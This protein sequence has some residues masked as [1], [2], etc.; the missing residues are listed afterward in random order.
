MDKHITIIYDG[1]CQFCIRALRLLKRFD[2]KQT[3]EMLD[4]H[5]PETLA[6]FPQVSYEQANEAM[7]VISPKGKVY[8]GFFAFRRLILDLPRLWPLL[9][10]FYFPG[11]F[12]IG[13][14]IYAWIA[15]NRMKFGCQGD[16]CKI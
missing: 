2:P 5:A 3:I 16:S 6:K 8:R 10:A 9:I 11:A 7:L 14:K 15:A 13:P 12:L 4:Y 1:H